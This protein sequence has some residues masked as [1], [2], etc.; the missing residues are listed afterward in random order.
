MVSQEAQAM[1]E[2]SSKHVLRTYGAWVELQPPFFEINAPTHVAHDRGMISHRGDQQHPQKGGTGG[3]PSLVFRYSLFISLEHCAGGSL[4][5]FLEARRQ[6]MVDVSRCLQIFRSILKGVKNI[7]E[8]GLVHRDLKPSN[9]YFDKRG[10]LKIGDFGLSH[11][12]GYLYSNH[13]RGTAPYMAPEILQPQLAQIEEWEGKEKQDA[14]ERAMDMYS[15]GVIAVQLFSTK[16]PKGS[17]GNLHV[18][19]C[20]EGLVEEL[21]DMGP[22]FQK[23]VCSLLSPHPLHRPTAS[24]ALKQLKAL[25]AQGKNK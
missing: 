1:A 16:L 9:I 17:L 15:V 21:V 22:I 2:L 24:R 5:T 3:A 18:S 4:R 20:V 7:H 13:I 12:V 6:P 19:D 8:A 10:I 14:R 25:I 23:L 11:R